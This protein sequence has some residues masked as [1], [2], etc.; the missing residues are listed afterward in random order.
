MTAKCLK[1]GQLY[2]WRNQRG[3]KMPKVCTARIGKSYCPTP[4]ARS[5]HPNDF[6]FHGEPC[7]GAL[8]KCDHEGKPIVR[9]PQPKRQKADCALCGHSGMVPGRLNALTREET[10]LVDHPAGWSVVIWNAKFQFISMTRDKVTIPEGTL[11]C[12]HHESY[13][14]RRDIF[15]K[16]GCDPRD[17]EPYPI[18]LRPNPSRAGV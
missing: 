10:F 5:H 8:V 17:L 4:C 7:G 16:E 14:K 9:K 11:V 2:R 18:I 15:D 13:E 6:C 12:W 3:A 1:C